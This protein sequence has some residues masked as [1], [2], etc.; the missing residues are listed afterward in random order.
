MAI[1]A[2]LFRVKMASNGHLWSKSLSITVEFRGQVF[3]RE[4]K[5]DVNIV[6]TLFTQGGKTDTF[7]NGQFC[8]LKSNYVLLINKKISQIN[9]LSF[10]GK[11]HPK[12]K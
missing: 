11:F 2:I 9:L 6:R 3:K 1:A 12:L 8:T 10:F 7:H 4:S 5:W